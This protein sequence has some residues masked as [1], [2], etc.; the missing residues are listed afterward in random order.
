PSSGAFSGVLWE[1]SARWRDRLGGGE[2]RWLALAELPPVTRHDLHRPRNRDR[3]ERAQDAEQVR[4]DQ[5]GGDDQER[6]QG[7][8]AAVDGGLQQVVLELLVHDQV[9]QPDDRVTREVVRRRDQP[10]DDPGDR[11]TDQRDQIEEGHQHGERN[12]ER[13][14]EDAQDDPGARS[15]D[16][17]DRDVADDVAANRAVHVDRDLPHARPSS[18]PEF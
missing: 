3:D 18:G 16:D 11:R 8:R 6:V 7:N 12:G 9:D 14:A 13:N 17:R 4:T 5:D 2:R 15:G 10:D 1:L